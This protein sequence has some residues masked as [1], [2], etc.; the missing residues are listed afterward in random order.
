MPKKKNPAPAA[1]SEKDKS[2]KD[3]W[4]ELDRAIKQAEAAEEAESAESAQ[5]AETGKFAQDEMD[6]EE[7]AEA[8]D[9]EAILASLDEEAAK[10]QMED[11]DEN[12][13]VRALK[14]QLA[15]AKEKMVSTLAQM[16]NHEART[17]RE[18][19]KA[20]HFAN[21]RI[22][23]KLLP[24]LDTMVR[25]LE[26][27]PSEDPQVKTLRHGMELTL[28]MLLKVMQEFGVTVIEP[29]PGDEFNPEQH[30]AM[31]VQQDST[32]ADNTVASVLQNGYMLQDR[33]LRAAMVIVNRVE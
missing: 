7:A 1:S 31:T 32:Q 22:I 17:A 16:K 15:D 3:K 5:A 28:D 25:G 14:A 30:E 29:V 20:R 21:E 27:A 23:K 8:L 19:T 26:S 18:M 12:P 9:D 10:L 33:V 13:E 24:V 4:E 2:A 6:A 11:M